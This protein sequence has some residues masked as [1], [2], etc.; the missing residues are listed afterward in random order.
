M[1]NRNTGGRKVKFTIEKAMT[2]AMGVFARNPQKTFNYKQMSKQLLLNDQRDRDMVNNALQNL[3][4][5]GLIEKVDR[6]RYKMVPRAG[7]VNG[8]IDMTYHGYAFL[9]SEEIEQDVFIARSNLG[10][11]MDGDLVKVHI[12]PRK[13]NDPR[14]SGEV[15]EIVERARETFVGIV[16]VS[17]NYAFLLP[18]SAKMPFDIFIP[19]EKLKGAK[20]GQKA[21]AKITDWPEKVKN[22]FGEVVDILGYPGE[23]ET[24]MHSILAEFEL[25]YKFPKDVEETAGKISAK[26]SQEEIK[27]RRDVRNIPTFTIDPADAKDFDDA[28]SLKKLKNGNY[29]VGI[30]IADVSFYVEKDSIIDSEG[31][32]RGTSIYLVDRVV[33]ML[34]EKLSNNLCSLRPNEDKLCFSV[35]VEVTPAAKVVNEW[36]GRTVINSDRRFD[37]DEAQ[38]IIESGE[39]DMKEEVLIFHDLATRLREKRYKEGSIN[40][41]RDEVKFHL[42]EEGRPLGVYFKIQKESNHLIEEFMLLANRRVAEYA[43]RGGKYEKEIHPQELR[44]ARKQGKT[45][46]Y[47]IHDLPDAEKLESF[48]HFIRKFGYEINTGDNQRVAASMNRVLNS[49]KGK[50]EQHVIENMA[51]RAMAKARYSTKN[52]GH[53][54]L[55]FKDYAHFTSPIRRYPDLMVH[56]LLAFYLDGGDSK[57]ASKYERR[58]DHASEMERRAVEAERASIK[59]KQV[60]FMQDKVGQEFEGVISGLTDWGIYTE[61]VENKCEGM[62]SLQSLMDDFYEFDEDE[63]KIIGRQ[64]GKE[65][66]IG[67][68]IKIEVINANLSKRQL[69]FKMVED[70]E[71]NGKN[72]G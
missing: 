31:Y 15:I 29:E 1:A 44:S 20:H 71:N 5:Q 26:I 67:A 53:Y 61:I 4:N 70:N 48:T 2:Q 27:K 14:L 23:N 64:S 36:F 7:Y 69:D 17:R 28:L 51:L 60:E 62:I 34:P 12:L 25:P 39:G 10:R 47:R 30:H 55:A 38:Q 50:K 24:E 45:F 13:K 46:V 49:V 11:A 59:Y 18:D 21:V 22:P 54:G 40:F 35:I 42:D 57:K 72:S 33:P 43:S 66:E 37:Y 58:C 3:L 32:D 16:E 65:F 56:R 9:K 19:T 6:G 8:T 68:P 41:E 52:V 63:Y